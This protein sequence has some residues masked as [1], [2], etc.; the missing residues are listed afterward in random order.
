MFA[1]CK[2][3][4]FFLNNAK[5]TF[6]VKSNYASILNRQL[7]MYTEIIQKQIF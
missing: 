3:E 6:T 7:R 4:Q 1:L 2:A 5:Y